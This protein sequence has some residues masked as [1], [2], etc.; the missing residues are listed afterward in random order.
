MK[1]SVFSLLVLLAMTACTKDLYTDST[2]ADDLHGKVLRSVTYT[3][4][5]N[6]WQTNRY[7]AF[8]STGALLEDWYYYYDR[9][10]RDEETG[11]VYSRATYTRDAKGR[12]VRSEYYNHDERWELCREY[13][14]LGRLVAENKNCLAGADGYTHIR[15]YYDDNTNHRICRV[16]EVSDPDN[17]EY[18]LRKDSF[19]YTITQTDSR[20]NWLRREWTD[21][22]TQTSFGGYY[23]SQS[24]EM[25]VEG[26]DVRFIQYA[27][28]ASEP[29][30]CVESETRNIKDCFEAW[31]RY[32]VVNLTWDEP[33][34]I[35]RG[36]IAKLRSAMARFLI[37][38]AYAGR[39]V[40][41]RMARQGMEETHAATLPAECKSDYPVYYR[42]YTL[43]YKGTCGDLITYELQ[44]QS[45]CKGD[46]YVRL[47]PHYFNFD[48]RSNEA[49]GFSDLLMEYEN[50][51][52]VAN[53]LGNTG[54]A[55][56]H[57]WPESSDLYG[58]DFALD[59]T[60]VLFHQNAQDNAGIRMHIGNLFRFMSN[61]GRRFMTPYALRS[62]EKPIS[63]HKNA[64][65]LSELE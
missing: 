61:R 62:M 42:N 26:L 35:S 50:Y 17:E 59:G 7:M 16:E 39:T 4:Y 19:V 58:A 12:I 43:S 9:A 60:D 54:K 23:A 56:G 32:E 65:P 11:V 5:N 15:Y 31:E 30:L 18:T 49:V 51:E 53:M 1:K 20:D 29:A 45:T 3:Y 52:P 41:E 28:E 6:L 57:A 25:E 22:I 8:D 10:F 13:D 44:D 34:S 14:K 24:T 27:D 33:V 46:E 38:D 64:I 36:D 48:T 2:L 55:Q 40:E 47:L 21:Y 63:E 37:P